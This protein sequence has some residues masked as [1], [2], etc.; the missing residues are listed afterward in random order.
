MTCRVLCHLILVLYYMYSN[1]IIR[2]LA[3]FDGVS[4]GTCICSYV[5]LYIKLLYSKNYK[6]LVV[7]PDTQPIQYTHCRM[8]SCVNCGMSVRLVL[9]SNNSPY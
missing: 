7:M 5:S 9:V 4:N 3:F 8:C 2:L 6:P 1:L